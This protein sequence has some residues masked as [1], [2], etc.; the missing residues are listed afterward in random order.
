MG[1]HNDRPDDDWG[2]VVARW[3]FICTLV[4]AVLYVGTVFAFILR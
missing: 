4:L 3:T 1:E 2:D